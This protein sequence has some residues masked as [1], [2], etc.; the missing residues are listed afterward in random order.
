MVGST[1]ET[2]QVENGLLLEEVRVARRASEIT[3]QLVVEQFARMEEIQHLI[4]QMNDSLRAQED[5]ARWECRERQSAGARSGDDEPD[6][7]PMNADR[8]TSLLLDTELGWNKSS[9]IFRQQ[10]R[11]ATIINDIPTPPRSRPGAWNW[12]ANRSTCAIASRARST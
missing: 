11:R 2:L 4:E 10:R 3:A 8:Y 12:N 9:S 5:P 1:V 6:C 7:T